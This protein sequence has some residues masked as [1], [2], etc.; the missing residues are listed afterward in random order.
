MMN[1]RKLA[2]INELK[3]RIDQFSEYL[4]KYQARNHLESERDLGNRRSAPADVIDAVSVALNELG[5]S[6]KL[7]CAIDYLEPFHGRISAGKL[8]YMA[9]TLMLKKWVEEVQN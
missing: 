2:G 7:E 9:I 1:R 8:S 4:A 5:H 3:E 6:E